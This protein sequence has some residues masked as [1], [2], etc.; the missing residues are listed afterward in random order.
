MGVDDAVRCGSDLAERRWS[1][2]R[3][4]PPRRRRSRRSAVPVTMRE[5]VTSA[6]CSRQPD[7]AQHRAALLREARTCRGSCWPCPRY[8][9]PCRAARRWSAR[10]CRRRRRPRCCRAAPARA[11][12]PAPADRRSSPRSAGARLAQLAAVDGDEGRAEALDAGIILVAG[13]LVDGA[14]AAE[15]G[16]QRLDRNAVR[17]HRAIAA[18]LADRAD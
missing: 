6:V 11:A 10:R 15:F 16:F 8:A 17:L 5:Q 2:W 3:R 12:T 9:R 18:A 1:P 4:P 7:V 14:L 13:R